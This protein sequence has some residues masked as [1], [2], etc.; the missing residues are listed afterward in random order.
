VAAVADRIESDPGVKVLI[1][2]RADPD[3][4]IIHRLT[5]AG[6]FTRQPCS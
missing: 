3:W 1:I 6:G 2:D 5:S 4:F